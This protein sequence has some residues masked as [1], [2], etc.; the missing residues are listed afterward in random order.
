MNLA[1]ERLKFGRPRKLWFTED[2]EYIWSQLKPGYKVLDYGCGNGS[3]DFL[4][5]DHHSMVC[6]E[7]LDEFDK[8]NPVAKYHDR[9]EITG[10]YDMIIAR[11]VVEHMDWRADGGEIREFL[12]W[13]LKHSEHLITVS[14]NPSRYYSFKEDPTHKTE[15]NNTFYVA[16]CE[17]VGW[18][19]KD[20]V[21]SDLKLGSKVF[22]IPR[23]ALSFFEGVAPLFSHIVSLEDCRV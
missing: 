6:I 16:L 10:K 11:H 2:K 3:I 20:V 23:L 22:F 13:A 15:C 18:T 19:V 7:G 17:D 9:S 8:R 21:L 1:N 5:T 12:E 14:P 4:G